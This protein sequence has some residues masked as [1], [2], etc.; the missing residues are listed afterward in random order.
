[1][2]CDSDLGC[3]YKHPKVW[4]WEHEKVTEFERAVTSWSRNGTV[5]VTVKEK[6]QIFKN[7]FISK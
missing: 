6:K 3:P 1:M 5:T 2:E 4:I 7:D